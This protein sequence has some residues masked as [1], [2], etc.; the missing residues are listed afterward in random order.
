LLIAFEVDSVKKLLRR[1]EMSALLHPYKYILTEEGR[2]YFR[3]ESGIDYF[4]YFLDLSDYGPDL[5][6]FNFERQEIPEGTE[7][8]APGRDVLDTVCQI[9][10]DFFQQ[11]TNAMLFVCDSSDGR[12]EGRRR[13]FSRKFDSVNDGSYEKIDKDGRT[14]YYS[15]FSSLIFRK[16]NPNKEHLLEAFERICADSLITE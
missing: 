10:L 15:L 11:Q 5:Y 1:R 14:E 8:K 2:Y 12:A 13:L 3:T 4:A 7:K 16:D 9:L 6:T